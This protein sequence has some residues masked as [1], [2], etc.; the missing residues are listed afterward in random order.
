MVASTIDY[1]ISIDTLF[2]NDPVIGNVPTSSRGRVM[3]GAKRK[4][5]ANALKGFVQSFLG[6]DSMIEICLN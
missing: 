6:P 5:C 1:V 2:G 4:E 3:K